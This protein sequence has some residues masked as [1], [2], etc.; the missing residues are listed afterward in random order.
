METTRTI[1][2]VG[3]H[4]DKEKK[5][6]THVVFGHRLTGKDLFQ[7]DEDPLGQNPTQYQ[8]LLVRAAI[9]EFG[10]LPMP[11]ALSVLLD[12]DSIDREDL[13]EGQNAYSAMTTEGHES[14]FLPDHK[15]RL[16]WGFKINDVI[17]DV[18][19]F[20]KRVTGR[21]DIE[22]DRAS[23]SPGIRRTCF[24]IG[25]QI[26]RISNVH[27]TASIEGAVAVKHFESLDGAD[28]ATLR[29]AAEMWRQSF[30]V[31][32]TALSRNGRGPDRHGADDENRPARV[33]DS[34]LADRAP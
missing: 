1:D 20:G 3:G 11:V 12:L 22:A 16:G 9:T 15:V 18:V 8:S 34:A 17:Y 14:E 19:Q 31:G 24:L 7:A 26:S 5:R 13:I 33:S 25:K 4:V 2:L 23:L 21:E 29:G 6:H 32:G 28:I 27:N 10:T 30:R